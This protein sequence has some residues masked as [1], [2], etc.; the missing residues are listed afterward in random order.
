[1][2]K[3]NENFGRALV[4][5]L[6]FATV[7]LFGPGDFAEKVSAADCSAGITLEVTQGTPDVVSGKVTWVDPADVWVVV[8]VRTDKWYIQ[9]YADERAYLTVNADGTYKTWIRDWHQISAFVIQKG[10]N[11]LSQQQAQRP[12]PLSLVRNPSLLD[13]G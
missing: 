12:F 3:V 6:M 7:F 4:F 11:A 2:K 9:P 5:F 10:Y 8:F 1:M 13:R